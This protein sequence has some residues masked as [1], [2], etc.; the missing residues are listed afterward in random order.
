MLFFLTQLSIRWQFEHSVTNSILSTILK[1]TFPS[2]TLS[3]C[4]HLPADAFALWNLLSTPHYLWSRME[5]TKT[6]QARQPYPIY[7]CTWRNVSESNHIFGVFFR[8]SL[9]LFG[10]L[11]FGWVGLVWNSF[12]VV[13][14]YLD[15]AFL[16]GF[17]Y[18]YTHFYC[19]LKYFLHKSHRFMYPEDWL[20][21]WCLFGQ[22]W[23]TYIIIS[24][25]HLVRKY[26]NLKKK[27]EEGVT[28][29]FFFF[30]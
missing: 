24:V 3:F 13:C 29:V 2:A 5:K 27:I 11:G 18:I 17:F 8:F 20:A 14:F 21:D 19:S 22:W 15:W 7:P 4:L 30:F 12:G 16:F 23:P 25:L 9:G 28:I 10:K 26:R 1:G 6:T